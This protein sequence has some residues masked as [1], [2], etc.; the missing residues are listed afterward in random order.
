[1]VE[2]VKGKFLKDMDKQGDPFGGIFPQDNSQQQPNPD[3]TQPETS[4]TPETPP[5][6][7]EQDMTEYGRTANT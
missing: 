3:P 1:M 6:P 2:S 4:N 5:K 7:E